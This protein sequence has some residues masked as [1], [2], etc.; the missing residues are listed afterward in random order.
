MWD[1]AGK[2]RLALQLAID[3]VT[4]G[5]TTFIGG[6][7]DARFRACE[8]A[9]GRELWTCKLDYS[10][11]ATPMTFRGQDGK[12]YVGIAATGGSFLNSPSGGESLIMFALP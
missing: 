12:Q 11:H 6:T 5:G 4:A 2:L 10:A 1:K 8:T 3:I 9:T 7:D